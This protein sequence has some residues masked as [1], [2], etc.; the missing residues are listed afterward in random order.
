VRRVHS[1][2]NA[3]C[4]AVEQIQGLVSRLPAGCPS[5]LFVFDAGYDAPHVTQGLAHLPVA[6]LVRLGSGRCFYATRYRWSHRPRQH[7]SKFSCTDPATWPPLSAEHRT[8]DQLYGT[9]RVCA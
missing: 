1:T 3:N 4:V 6:V 9:M 8:E 5:T 2:E 7:G